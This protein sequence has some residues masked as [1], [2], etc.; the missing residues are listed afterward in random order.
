MNKA[1][2]I[3]FIASLTLAGCGGSASDYQ[4]L[5]DEYKNVMCTGMDPNAT[6]TAKTEALSRQ[7]ALNEEYKDA[8][9]SLPLK[10]KQALMMAWAKAMAEVA[11]GNC[12]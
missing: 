6:M 2:L 1:L 5:V 10:E 11:D 7:L 3:L 9:N 4:S 8:L 12:P